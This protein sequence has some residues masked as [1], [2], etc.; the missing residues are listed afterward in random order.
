MH[1]PAGKG[2]DPRALYRQAAAALDHGDWPLAQ[3][4][5]EFLAPHTRGHGGVHYI[6]G[7]AALQMQQLDRAIGHLRQAADQ[8]TG[9]PEYLA[10]YARAL[11]MAHRH[12]EAVA[13]ADRAL[14]QDCTDAVVLDTLG[15]VYSRANAHGTAIEAYRRACA[16]E[17]AHAGF[18]F[19]LAT[20]HMVTGDIEAAGREF[21]ACIAA[22]P[23]YWRG[24]LALAQLRRYT[25][26]HNHVDTLAAQIARHPG[27]AGAQLYLHMALAKEL[28]DL[29]DYPRAFDHYTRGKAAQRKIEGPSAER[30]A[31]TFAAVRR[32]FDRPLEAAPGHDSAE[33]IFVLGMPRSGTTL[34]DRILS[35]HSHVHSAGELADFGVAL[36]NA[37]GRRGRS[38]AGVLASLDPRF[39]AW[40]ALGRAYVDGTRAVGTGRSPRFVDKL[41]HNFLHI[42]FIARALPN[43]KIVCL[44]REPMDTCL[45]NF[46]QPFSPGLPDY[47]Y[48]Q[49]LLDTGRYYL[50]FDRLMAFWRER[51]PRTDP[52]TALR[53]P[54]RRPGTRHAR[55]ARLLRPAVGGRL[56]AFRGQP[57]AG[58]HGQRGAGAFGH[59]PRLGAA[60]ET[61]RRP[62]RSAAQAAVRRRGRRRRLSPGARVDHHD[63]VDRT[64]RH[65]QLAAGAQ[66]FDHHVHVS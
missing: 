20:S 59:E 55:A 19:N 57:R 3:R 22:D 49:D 15:S 47:A 48:A 31:A 44:R 53:S 43:A 51:L 13:A 64:G 41:P 4:L 21:E 33:P 65:A 25:Q 37:G 42:G 38:L 26:A 39:N 28:E 56:P 11:S 2:G 23:G 66:G 14:A 46:R 60:L 16:L 7:V 34:T 1:V 30:D 62:A 10:Q 36:W 24:Y 18:R 6:A 61:L 12:A 63:A 5:A 8:G 9:H 54:G 27:D 58:L 29:G 35:M 40:E 17:P 52:G 45:S 32:W 50:L